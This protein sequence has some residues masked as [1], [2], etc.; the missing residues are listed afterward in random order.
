MP[1]RRSF[2]ASLAL[3]VALLAFPPPALCGSRIERSLKLDPGG[4]FALETP[5]GSIEITG[6]AGSGARIVVTSRRDDLESLLDIRFEEKPGSVRVVAEKKGVLSSWFGWL[7]PMN[8]R[9]EIQVP[10]RTALDLA[11][12]GGSIQV[13]SVRGTSE[14]ETSG[15]SIHVSDLEGDLTA[16]TSGGGILLATIKGKTLAHTSGGSIEVHALDG[17]L[18]ARTGGG[19]ITLE[20]VTGDLVARTSGGSIEISGAG[21][22]VDAKTSGG[23]IELTFAPGNDKG[24]ELETSGGSI[25]VRLDP[26]VA[27]EIEASTSA[28]RVT[29]EIPLK[30]TGEASKSSIRGSLG[31][32]GRLLRLHTSAGGIVIGPI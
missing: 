1:G 21:G 16:R 5:G 4:A 11:T 15:G 23:S 12:S 18:E 14:V 17:A 2:L 30:I 10:S 19:S 32:G 20:K 28:G 27:L 29:T 31:S 22:H 24:G 3:A 26:K 7:S 25:E 9:Y 6:T 13:S 8:L